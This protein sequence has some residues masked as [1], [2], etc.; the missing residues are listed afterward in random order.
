MRGNCASGCWGR[1]H[2]LVQAQQSAVEHGVDSWQVAS[3]HRCP[4]GLEE[5]QI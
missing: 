2:L 5:V 1:W 4:H 3:M